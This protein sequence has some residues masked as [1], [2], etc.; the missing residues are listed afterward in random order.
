MYKELKPHG[1]VSRYL[2]AIW[3]SENTREKIILPDNCTDIIIPLVENREP[4][5]VGPMTTSLTH[6]G[7]PGER[8]LGLRFRPGYSAAFIRDDL[9]YYT[10][11]TVDLS[12]I[13]SDPF[14]EIRDNYLERKEIDV[15]V[16]SAI[17]SRLYSGYSLDSR[18]GHV[19]SLI[20]Q[21]GGSVSIQD[22]ADSAGFSKRMLEIKFKKM[23]GITPKRFARIERFNAC[24]K[25]ESSSDF[26]GYYDQSHMIKEFKTFTGLTPTE[27]FS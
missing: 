1:E 21:T 25:N 6:T 4:C 14:L 7:V 20:K 22:A 18:V 13:L 27:F 9:Y 16:L 12:E 26:S 23:L 11:K 15:S 3:L 19:V 17:V 8:L 10:D 5:F 2:E 24:F